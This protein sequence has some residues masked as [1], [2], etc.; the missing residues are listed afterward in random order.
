MRQFFNRGFNGFRNQFR[1]GRRFNAEQAD[2][3]FKAWRDY[4]FSTHFWGPAAN[5]GIPIAA[6]ADCQKSPEIISPNMTASLILYSV[7]FSRFAW[8][9]QPRN[10]LLLACHLTNTAAQCTQMFRYYNY[11]YNGGKQQL[12]KKSALK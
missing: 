3:S 11:E 1:A 6:I 2:N 10:M 9:V 8:M 12:A 4:F 7:L 5:W